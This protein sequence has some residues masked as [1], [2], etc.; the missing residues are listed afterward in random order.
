MNFLV[1]GARFVH[2]FGSRPVAR[3]G[4]ADVSRCIVD[5][6]KAH[7][8]DGNSLLR[9]HHTFSHMMLIKI[10]SCSGALWDFVAD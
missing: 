1:L 3:W 2:N 10:L 9:L 7:G 5:E 8:G 6:G 4:G